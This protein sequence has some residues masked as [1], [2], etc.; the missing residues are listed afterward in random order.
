MGLL[1]QGQPLRELSWLSGDAWRT[2]AQWGPI[3]R[4]AQ[5]SC[6]R[7][8]H[9]ARH[10]APPSPAFCDPYESFL[11]PGRCCCGDP[12][13]PNSDA[14]SH[15]A[16]GFRILRGDCA[17]KGPRR[18]LRGGRAGQ[19][20][21]FLWVGVLRSVA[22]PHPPPHPGFPLLLLFSSSS[23]PAPPPRR[24][25]VLAGQQAG[26]PHA[27][28]PGLV[29]SG[30]GAEGE[31]AAPS[32]TLHHSV[33]PG[34]P[35]PQDPPEVTGGRA[36]TFRDY[37]GRG[38]GEGRRREG[39][40]G[41][42]PQ[43]AQPELVGGPRQHRNGRVWLRDA[44]PARKLGPEPRAGSNTPRAPGSRQRPHRM[45]ARRA[46]HGRCRSLRNAGTASC[47]LLIESSSAKCLQ[48]AEPGP[49]ADSHLQI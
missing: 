34:I 29:L 15:L 23:P 45:E 32:Q 16:Q 2:R 1:V 19:S 30:G 9:M 13:S 48:A 3:P 41:P 24:S 7:T 10:A 20:T 21:G 4:R 33:P 28:C 12:L 22:Q 26:A 39:S 14:H 40:L 46:G 49:D 36:G 25:W 31:S 35:A 8:S 5:G 11:S 18:S 37:R 27:G 42:E 17:Q 47:G 43:L 38:P 6:L 44:E